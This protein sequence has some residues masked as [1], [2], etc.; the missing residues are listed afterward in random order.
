MKF[1]N[2]FKLSHRELDYNRLTSQLKAMA[3]ILKRGNIHGQFVDRLKWHVAP[4]FFYVVSFPTHVDIEAAVSCQLKCPMCL[5]HTMPSQLMHG[6]MDFELFK[7]IVDEISKEKVYSIKLSWRGEPLLNPNIVRMV[8]YAKKKDIKDVAFLTNGERLNQDL[9]EALVDAGLDWISFSIDGLNENYEKIR[10]PETFENIVKKVMI[11]KKYRDKKNRKKPLIRVQTIWGAIKNYPE[12]Y[13][14]FWENIADKVYV[15]AD[16]ARG[17]IVDFPRVKNYICRVPWQ[18]IVVGWNGIVPQ[19]ITDYSE[20]N[21][22]GD[23]K[24]ETLREIWHGKKFKQLR[25]SIKEGK[26][27]DNKACSVC[28]DTGVMYEKKVDIGKKVIKINLYRGQ[29]FDIAKISDKR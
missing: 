10:F 21:V 24:K 7:K 9:A 11:L 4:R 18:R 17:D 23:V 22:L 2:L 28:H 27:Y 12:T 3:F 1:F 29:E 15:I 25:M 26:I 16:Q 13:F 19:C 20:V 5:R 14:Q 6:V 8:E